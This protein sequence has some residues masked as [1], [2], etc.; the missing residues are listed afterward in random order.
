MGPDRDGRGTAPADPDPDAFA[1]IRTARLRLRCAH[2]AD[3]PAV[4]ALMTPAIS[5]WLGA[6]PVPYT[7]ELALA[8][9][10]DWR[11]RAPLRRAMP[12]VVCDGDGDGD[13]GAVIGWI[14]VLARDDDAGRASMGYW[15]G[16]AHAGG[17]LMREA[18]AALVPAA[19]RFL[20]VRA[21]EA[22]AQPEN[23]ASFAV[24]RAAGLRPVG[25]RVM[26]AAARGRDELCA[27]YEVLRPQ[28]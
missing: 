23:R 24:M 7:T 4:A 27:V 15:L 19:F 10:A 22:V 21:I 11:A 12:C 3:A 6:W 1:P 13:G 14:H 17:G 26:F 25:E 16:E 20:G 9:I 2:P 28:P 8:R 18:A 5:R